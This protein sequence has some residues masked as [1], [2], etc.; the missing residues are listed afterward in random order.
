MN[1][2]TAEAAAQ[3]PLRERIK[4][5]YKNLFV[6][7]FA[8]VMLFAY[9]VL[10][11]WSSFGTG[12]AAG[13]DPSQLQLPEG[14]ELPEGFDPSQMQLPEGMELPEGF[15]P[16]QMQQLPEGMEAPEGME[17]PEG[18]TPP[19][20]STSQTP[21]D[22]QTTGTTTQEP[23]GAGG[24]GGFGGG[25]GTMPTDA[26]R[27]LVPIAA[28]IALAVMGLAAWKPRFNTLATAVTFLVGLAAGAY[29]VAFFAI[30]ALL[31]IPINFIDTVT[32]GFWIGL[33]GTIGLIGQLFISRP[34]ELDADDSNAEAILAEAYKKRS[35]ISVTQNLRVAV[36][37]LLGNKLRSGLTMLGMIIGVGSV[38]ALLSVGQGATS[39]ITEQIQGTGVNLITVSPGAG[40]GFGP[41]GGPGGGSQETLTY[42]DAEAIAEDVEGIS[43]VLPQYSTNLDVRSEQNNYNAS[44]LGVAADYADVRSIDIDI[45][46]Y[47]TS[48]HYRSGSM[49][50]VLG[51]GASEELFGGLNPLGEYIR[52]DGQRFEV[53]GVLGEQDG[54]FGNDPNLQI[55]VPLTSGYRHLFDARATGSGNYYVSSIVVELI[56]GDDADAVTEDIET[57]L[58]REH[59][60]TGDDEND[61]NV[62]D[63]QQL[64][65][66]ASQ[67]TGILTVLLGAIGGISL[68]V[69][70]IG[71]MNIMLVSVTER[72][73]EIG[74]RKAIGAR[75]SHILQQ[76]LIETILLSMLG[77]IFGVAAGVGV[78]L[79]ANA[80]GALTATVSLSSIGLGL[81]FSALVGI[82]FGVY[83]ANQAASLE[84]IEALR[85]E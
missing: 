46:E 65:E 44:V 12:G 68:V 26:L 4:P 10:S 56:N 63:Q 11:P 9:V 43:A 54:G 20:S 16:S 51:S 32:I 73:K 42:R 83:P 70:G 31:P 71:I 48:G 84:P 75:R 41:G 64:L 50:A 66:T 36:G 82:F 18:F 13:F 85:Y 2:T 39:S 3:V 7:V 60:L 67:I 24:F 17:M 77:G 6:A 59:E 30:D 69:G 47:I 78:A 28:V 34:R 72:T 21:S 76:F 38:V 55:H 1:T 52:I 27:V 40:G 45:G 62:S 19:T 79:I 23:T 58:R 74:L 25:F 5:F 37:A 8:L 33:V 35:S 80:T 53:I 49:V 61:F 22:G 81:G 15:D 14:M 57:V 29:Y